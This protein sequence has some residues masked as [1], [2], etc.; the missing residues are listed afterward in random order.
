MIRFSTPIYDA[1]LLRALGHSIYGGASVG[2]CL[3][4]AAAISD[5][6]RESW[7]RQWIGLADRT[8]ARAESYALAGHHV[9]AVGGFLRA[10]NYYRTSYIFHYEAPVPAR[11][12]DG[13]RRQRDAFA[14]AAALMPRPLERTTIPFD[15]IALPAW[16]CSAGAHRRPCVV[17]VGGYDSTAEES[18]FW[19]AAAANARGYHA[20]VFDG[21]GQGGVLFEHGVPFRPDWGKV[22]SAVVDAVVTRDDVG[23]V[24]VVGESFG[25]YLAPLGAAEDPRIAALVVDPAQTGLWRA[26]VNRLPLPEA[27]KKNL[28]SGP[29]WLVAVVERLLAHVARKPVAGWALRRGMLAHGRGT[30]WEYFVEMACYA[31]A[32]IVE[33]IRCPTMVCDA[34]DDDI[35]ASARSFFERLRCEKSYERFTAEDGA[36][37]HC[38]MGNRALFH[39]KVFG[40]LEQV[41]LAPAR[42]SSLRKEQGL[43]ANTETETT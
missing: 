36:A 28:P 11:T 41:Q 29:R 25:G 35:A 13:Y 4:T 9:S 12:V 20:V 37:D 14:R 22:I 2:E 18:Y 34:A 10:S 19:N 24:A 39:E 15:G 23:S 32:G 17:C 5:G 31:D 30:A 3:A 26:A 43:S 21:P 1:Q 7:H 16:F 27:L 6:D 8:V 42:G 38:V 40:W 33:K